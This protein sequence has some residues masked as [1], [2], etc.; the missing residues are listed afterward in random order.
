MF[1]D[2]GIQSILED[3]T[4]YQRLTDDDSN[5]EIKWQSWNRP[6]ISFKLECESDFLKARKRAFELS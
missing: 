5:Q 2:N 6:T 1:S 3:L 4:S